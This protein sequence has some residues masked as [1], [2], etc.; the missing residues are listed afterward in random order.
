MKR[1]K[2]KGKKVGIVFGTFAPMHIGHV[3]LIQRAKRENDAVLVVVSGTN[4]ERDRGQQIGLGLNRRFRYVRE[5]FQDDELVVVDKLDEK[6][7]PAYPDGWIPWLEAIHELIKTNTDYEFETLNFYVFE[8][9]YVE[10]VQQYFENIFNDEFTHQHFCDLSPAKK[11]TVTLVER[12]IIPISATEIRNHPFKYWKYITK[13]FRRH[14][15]K[16]VLIVG[17]ASG[18]K[19]TLVK[20]LARVYNA[21]YSLEYA[22][23]YQETFNVRDEELRGHDYMRLLDGQYAQ[24][25]AIIDEGSH[26]GLVITDTN[27]SVTKAYYDYYC[28][29]TASEQEKETIELMYQVIVARE[30]WDL[31]ILVEPNT[32]YVNDGFRD[33][34]M[35]EQH[36]RDEFTQHLEGL[37]Y[38]FHGELIRVNGNFFEN[39]EIIKGL[40]DDKLGIEI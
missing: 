12:S 38:P 16:K 17:S 10:Q 14:F 5:V 1:F 30:K 22:R 25:S 35:S 21:P 31:V 20:D 13:P 3:D 34:T 8:E 19:T 7:M 32:E 40:I 4:T 33:M 6:D 11:V 18:G 23:E 2:L 24:T 15:T 39:Y 29:E 28:A 36:I 37:L 26:T 9:E 27:S